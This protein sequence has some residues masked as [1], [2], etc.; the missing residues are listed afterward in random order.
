[1]QYPTQLLILYS[2]KLRAI[3]GIYA[4]ENDFHSESL[5]VSHD[6]SGTVGKGIV[7]PDLRNACIAGF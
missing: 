6:A 2:P 3:S 1:M 7:V 4:V 5:G